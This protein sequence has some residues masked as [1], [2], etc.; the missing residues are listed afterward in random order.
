VR[1]EDYE[2][3]RL[4]GLMAGGGV[5]LFVETCSPP[6]TNRGRHWYLWAVAW[7]ALALAGAAVFLDGAA[8]TFIG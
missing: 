5:W 3:L 7:V 1:V 2:L 6:R 8:R 4:G